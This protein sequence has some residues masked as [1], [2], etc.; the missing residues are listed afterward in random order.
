[1]K[2]MK[3]ILVL[4]LASVVAYGCYYLW[5]ALPIISGYGAK[6][7]CSCVMLGNRAP[8]DVIKNELGR[9]FLSLGRF[10]INF[11]DSSA[12]GSVFGFTKRKAIYR[13]G[14]GCTLLSELTEEEIRSQEIKLL[15]TPDLNSDT[16]FWSEGE[17]L[18]DTLISDIN[19]DELHRVVSTAFEGQAFEKH[20]NTRAVLVIYD[21]NIV[22]ERYAEGFD[23]DS[24]HIGWSMTKSLTSALIGILVRDGK[25]D[26]NAPAPIKEWQHDDRKSITLDNLLHANSGLDWLERYDKQ[27]YA[28]RMLFMKKDMGTYAASAPLAHNPGEVFQYSSGTTN[29][30]SRII[31]EKVGDGY[32]YD[33]P[34]KELFHK[35]GMY[36]MVLESDPGGTFVGSSY[37]FATARDWARFGLLYLNDGVWNGERILPQGWVEY[38]KTAAKGAEQGQYGAHF[39]LNKGEDRNPSNRVHPDVPVDLFWAAGHESQHVYIL[40]SKKLVVVK[41]CLS[42]G[43]K[44]D[45]NRFLADIIK[46]LPKEE[47]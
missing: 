35:I 26:V 2:L 5:S 21:G 4:V 41:L 17:K 38:T 11:Q 9:G 30:L 15:Q 37:A 29:I 45:D 47:L 6:Q 33:F 42:Q 31:R 25:L 44:L 32:Y 24:R 16:V 3:R 39:W 28:T 43:D 22:V 14:L 40:P 23:K 8:E 34:Y 27:C 7:L 36:S 18:P 19:Y 1:M 20:I 13:T 12:T 46:T 10:V